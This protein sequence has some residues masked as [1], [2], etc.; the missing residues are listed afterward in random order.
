MSFSVFYDFVVLCRGL[1]SKF[2][3]SDGNMMEY[4][5]VDFF[6]LGFAQFIN[7]SLFRF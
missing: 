1:L 4:V 2:V 7:L 5:V 6:H 3:R